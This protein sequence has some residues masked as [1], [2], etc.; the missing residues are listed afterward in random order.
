MRKTLMLTSAIVVALAAGFVVRYSVQSGLPLRL[1]PRSL[2]IRA[3]AQSITPPPPYTIELA[4]VV[5][6]RGYMGK[7]QDQAST[8]RLV[9]ARRSDGS[10]L[11]HYFHAGTDKDHPAFDDGDMVDVPGNA[12]RHLARFLGTVTTLP[13]N[14]TGWVTAHTQWMTAESG[15]LLLSGGTTAFGGDVRTVGRDT[16]LGFRTVILEING[17]KSWRALDLGCAPLKTEIHLV[18][19]SGRT[20]DN[21]QT[22]TRVTVGEPDP[23]LFDVSGEELA[24]SAVYERKMSYYGFDEATKA[25]NRKSQAN[26]LAH[27]DEAYRKA[28]LR[29]GGN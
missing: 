8:G 17:R 15:C 7:W 13:A 24:P 27:Q 10:T 2:I 14:G 21:V 22:A 18:D 6:S 20:V 29:R 25:K 19:D 9:L 3:H 26:L 5:T 23:S 28:Q 16:I 11:K 12:S 4:E 1:V